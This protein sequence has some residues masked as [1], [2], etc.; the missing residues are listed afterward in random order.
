[1]IKFIRILTVAVFTILLLQNCQKSDF[2]VITGVV[3]DSI[4]NQPIEGAYVFTQNGN[5]RTDKDGTFTLNGLHSGK[6][7]INVFSFGSYIQ[8]SKS[9]I[10][11][12]GQ[13]NKIDFELG[14][15]P[16]PEIQTGSVFDIK[17]NSAKI[18]SAINVK[19]GAYVY[20]Y[21]HCWSSLTSE[22]NLSDYEGYTSQGSGGGSFTF[23]SNLPNLQSE[24]LYYVRAYAS[25][26]EGIIYG[27]T[28]IFTPSDNTITSGLVALYTFNTFNDY[29]TSWWKYGSFPDESGNS[30]SLNTYMW[31]GAPLTTDRFGSNNSALLCAGS[32]Y[33]YSWSTNFGN[34]NDFAISFWFNKSSWAGADAPIINLSYSSFSDE[35]R[36]GEDAGPNKLYFD[37]KTSSGSTYKLTPQSAP[38]LNMWHHAVFLRNSTSIKLYIDNILQSSM[39]CDN[40]PIYNYGNYFF[41]GFDINPN[42]WSWNYFNGSLDDIRFYKRSLKESEIN[43]LFKN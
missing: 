24:K 4:T 11:T 41:V 9:V 15:V 40:A 26:N 1:M 43:Y 20:Q 5:A 21:G 27:N 22:P 42:T 28:V 2:L 12:D 38:S 37:I 36:I 18:N 10:I 7:Y 32:R 17:Y 34:I 3:R 8:K 33:T 35:I 25:T 30:T 6:Q 39:S 13:V 19:T 29:S 31:P 16:Q 23:T 14:R